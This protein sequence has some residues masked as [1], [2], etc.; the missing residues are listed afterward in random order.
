M[1]YAMQSEEPSETDTIES[2]FRSCSIRMLDYYKTTLLAPYLGARDYDRTVQ[3]E[4]DPQ[5]LSFIIY[6]SSTSTP[7]NSNECW[8]ML[9]ALV[10]A[11][12]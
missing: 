8:M 4:M 3:G 9:A 1:S 10:T 5:T 2:F 6:C 11:A 7:L 12:S